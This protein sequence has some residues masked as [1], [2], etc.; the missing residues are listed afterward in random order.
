MIPPSRKWDGSSARCENWEAQ[1]CSAGRRA[2]TPEIRLGECSPTWTSTISVPV[3]G[4]TIPLHAG[5]KSVPLRAK[6]PTATGIAVP[7]EENA[8]ARFAKA[9]IPARPTHVR[10]DLLHRYIV[11]VGKCGHE[12]RGSVDG[13]CL[14]GAIP[15]FA[16][17]NS[18]ALAVAW[19]AVIGVVTLFRRKQVLH[20]FLI[21][22]GEMPR[23]PA[24]P[25]KPRVVSA[26][27]AFQSQVTS[28][29]RGGRTSI[30][31]RVDRNISRAHRPRDEPT[32]NI[33]R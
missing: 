8:W 15:E 14:R 29:L 2:T 27:L 22:D 13:G 21:I 23:N 17:F 33:G 26:A 20:S 12:A 16:D 30:F 5:D 28:V 4:S 32:M 1:H 25:T 10:D 7:L 6:A 31:S 3:G 18:N 24:G 11:T 9:K 19:A